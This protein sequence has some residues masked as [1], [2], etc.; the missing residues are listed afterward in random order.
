MAALKIPLAALAVILATSA[1]G[2]KRCCEL[3]ATPSTL[4]STPFEPSERVQ[5]NYLFQAKRL[6]AYYN[7]LSTALRTHAPNQLA[8]L[9]PPAPPAHGYQILPKIV[10]TAPPAELRAQFRSS[11]YSWPATEELI[12]HTVGELVRAEAEL[13][14]AASL[15]PSAKKNAYEKLARSYRQ[16]RERQQNIDAHIQYNRLWQAE[17]AAHRSTYDRAT[18]LHDAVLERQA[19]V[20]ALTGRDGNFVETAFAILGRFPFGRFQ[21]PQKLA[22]FKN[23]LLE[24]ERVLARLIHDA[25][26][27]VTVPPFVGLERVANAWIFHLPCYTDIND[28][29]FVRSVKEE[30]EKIWR[31]RHGENEFR[32]SLSMLP[33]NPLYTEGPPATGDKIN[34]Q[35]HLERFPRDG[36]ILTTGAITTHV[37]GRAILLGPHEISPSVLAH[38]FGHIL[39]FKDTYFRGYRDLGKDGFQVVEVSAAN[40][41]IMGSS[42][43]GKV[44][45]SQFMQM[46]QGLLRVKAN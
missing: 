20:D 2:M 33:V 4:A 21:F 31:L 46:L 11:W 7:A 26:D 10:Q 25:T 29:D 34:P 3:E 28:G 45:L 19:I 39:G 6:R 12:H 13:K 24:R 44:R 23:R 37:L 38:E 16:L 40:D 5:A 17:I 15:N 41:D 36:A 35:Q 42:S 32:L 14:H 22:E 9:E 18:A 8:L 30:V 1:S 27:Q 43:I